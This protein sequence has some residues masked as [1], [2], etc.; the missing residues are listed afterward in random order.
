VSVN[1]LYKYA[2]SRIIKQSENISNEVILY[3]INEMKILYEWIS[4]ILI[5]SQNSISNFLN[6]TVCNTSEIIL[7][8]KLLNSKNVVQT[9]FN[10]NFL[11]KD[12]VLNTNYNELEKL[13]YVNE[14]GMNLINSLNLESIKEE[15][16]KKQ[17]SSIDINIEKIDLYNIGVL[18]YFFMKVSAILSVYNNISNIDRS[19]INEV[20]NK[21]TT[22]LKI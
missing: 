9:I 4:C 21:V 3:N 13:V 8:N 15:N 16:I 2:I 12:F 6:V 22:K 17:I 14:K 5:N 7:K 10:V 20:Q 11:E 1:N 19:F 18:M